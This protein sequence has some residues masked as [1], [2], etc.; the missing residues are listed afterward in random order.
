MLGNEE[1]VRGLHS[2]RFLL[3]VALARH[4]ARHAGKSDLTRLAAALGKNKAAIGDAD[5][6]M[7][8]DVEFHYAIAS[9]ARNPIFTALHGAMVDW[10]AEQRAVS[11]RNRAADA[12]AYEFHRRIYEAIASADADGAEVAMEQ[13]LNEVAELYWRQIRAKPTRKA[14]R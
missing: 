12:K 7:E 14:T 11:L 4:A 3:E 2:A 6:F 8:T 13:H 5:V 10:L 1:G 9:V